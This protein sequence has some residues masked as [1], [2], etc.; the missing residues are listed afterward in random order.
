MRFS[1]LK[2]TLDMNLPNKETKN[3]QTC[4]HPASRGF[5][6]AWLLAFTRLYVLLFSHL[7]GLF[8]PR[9]NCKD[10]NKPMWLTS[11]AHNF[12]NAKSHPRKK[13]LFVGQSHLI[14]VWK[15][16]HHLPLT[17]KAKY[18][19]GI[20]TVSRSNMTVEKLLQCTLMENFAVYQHKI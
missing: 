5:F 14:L 2:W 11:H 3:E 9:E 6:L 20:L 19:V 4:Y 7:V 15:V 10:V 18:D 8:M 17:N 13:P 12:T 16:S 1:G